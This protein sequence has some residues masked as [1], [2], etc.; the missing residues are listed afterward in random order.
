MN[1][2]S[3]PAVSLCIPTRRQPERLRRLLAHVARL[4][5]PGPLTVLVLDRDADGRTGEAVAQAMAPEFPFPLVSRVEALR[6]EATG[7]QAT[8]GQ[9]AWSAAWSAA[10]SVPGADYVA[11]LA[12]DEF[13]APR[14]LAE[15]IGTAVRYD[16]DVVGG[17]VFPLFDDPG[18]WLAESGLY[19][20]RRFVTG[21][22]DMIDGT[23]PLLIRRESL[24]P[25]LSEPLSDDLALGNGNNR[26]FLTRCRSDGRRFAWADDARVSKAVP[27]AQVTVRWLLL[28]GFHSGTEAAGRRRP[29]APGPDDRAKGW[30]KGIGLAALGLGLLPLAALRGRAALV[31]S[32]VVAARGVGCIAAEL[33]LA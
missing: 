25:Y 1:Q 33:G 19:S 24:A 6:S 26:E 8:A 16:A 31:R 3:R 2:P 29:S 22:V 9:T 10:C 15:M 12:E 30:G 18:Y 32:L 28:R 7:C 17:P 4:E 11:L 21:P 20:P 27:P 13:P 14:W 23:G 5:A